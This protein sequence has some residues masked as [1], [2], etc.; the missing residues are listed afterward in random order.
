MYASFANACFFQTTKSPM[1]N[2]MLDEL[3]KRIFSFT[4]QISSMAKVPL[5]G[6]SQ[7]NG[8]TPPITLIVDFYNTV[9]HELGNALILNVD[10]S[11]LWNLHTAN[12]NVGNI[13]S[14]ITHTELT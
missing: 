9:Y 3:L 7:E 4:I 1:S 11:E 12:S 2:V 5:F 8:C 13:P 14:I 10:H 6:K